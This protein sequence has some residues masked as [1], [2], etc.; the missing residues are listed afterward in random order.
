M[1]SCN[2]VKNL[3]W[4]ACK[5]YNIIFAD[6]RY[7]QKLH[8][9]KFHVFDFSPAIDV[10]CLILIRWCVSEN[11]YRKNQAKNPW[12]F[13]PRAQYWCVIQ[14]CGKAWRRDVRKRVTH[15]TVLLW[16][17]GTVILETGNT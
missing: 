12:V 16:Y 8:I 2:T 1:H 15:D 13:C 7:K 9:M 10:E 5:T 11:I 3:I 6:C 14:S 4:L 17:C